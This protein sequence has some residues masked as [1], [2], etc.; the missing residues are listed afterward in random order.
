L[1][2]AALVASTVLVQ[3]LIG[4]LRFFLLDN[5]N[6]VTFCVARIVTVQGQSGCVSA[7]GLQKKF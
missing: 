2:H 4:V 1:R 7:F 3:L 6:A 5:D